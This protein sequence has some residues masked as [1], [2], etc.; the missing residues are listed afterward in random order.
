MFEEI[1]GAGGGSNKST[2][3]STPTDHPSHKNS[4]KR[5]PALPLG[6]EN[7]V[8]VTIDNCGIEQKPSYKGYRCV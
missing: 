1:L 8:G 2:E 6:I 7:H 3:L 5:S 4:A